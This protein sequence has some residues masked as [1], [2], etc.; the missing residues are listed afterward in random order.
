[1]GKDSK[2][3]KGKNRINPT[4]DNLVFSI[5]LLLLF[6]VVD[7]IVVVNYANISVNNSELDIFDKLI[8]L[9]NVIGTKD[10]ME[11]GSMLGNKAI[12]K[13]FFET[14]K[15]L[16]LV[17][18]IIIMI[19]ITKIIEPKQD[20]KGIEH[21]SAE[22]AK[23]EDRKRFTSSEHSFPLADSLFLSP[24]DKKADNFN[25]VVV[26]GP[27]AGKTLR[28]IKP[29]IMQMVGSYVITDPKGE[30]YR[31][32]CKLLEKNGY[33]VKVL[34]L[35]EPKF[36][37]GYN[38]FKYINMDSVE[39]DVFTLVNCF[40]RNTTDTKKQGGDQFW[41]D[42]VKALLT[43]IIFYL[44][45]DTDEDKCFERVFELTK[46][47][48]ID[49]ETG[50][51]N[52]RKSEIERI[53][54]RIAEDDPYHPGLQAW[55]EFKLASGKTA[56][57]ILIS[58]A[59]RLNIWINQDICS[60]TYQDEMEFE[61]VGVE[62]TAIF[63]ITPD[64]DDNFNVLASMFYTQLFKT[65]F[66]EA[67]FHYNGRLPLL[68]SCE[69]DEF[70][71]IGEIPNFDKYI[72]T[73]R[74][75]NVR[76][77]II[78]QALSQLEKLYK[79][80]WEIILGCCY[81]INYLGTTDTKTHK[82][83]SE[84]LGKTTTLVKNRGESKSS[85]SH[86]VNDNGNYIARD[87]MSSDEVS[88]L[89]GMNSIVF[90][91]GLNPFFCNKFDTLHHPLIKYVGSSFSDGIPNNTDI[92]KKYKDKSLMRMEEVRERREKKSQLISKFKNLEDDYADDYTD[93]YT[94]KQLEEFFE[95]NKL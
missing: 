30:V 80:S 39:T 16:V 92:H 89:D 60:M 93:D 72:A 65:L 48:I 46:N 77:C 45:L 61:K 50:E 36:S 69:L 81:I 47:V 79:E 87:L 26:G 57:S 3:F 82:F 73:M 5:F 7:V 66:Y 40:M 14:Q 29:E 78:L 17:Y 62:K 22:W 32:T 43:A 31:D 41:D 59:V 85:K 95:K 23:K 49:E 25:E 28:K 33:K 27:G 51:I 20:F 1:M 37:D 15:N 53:F 84:R 2:N 12:L 18:G 9:G 6:V 83:V 35:I 91:R 67:D 58:L 63:L 86:S 75:R 13:E 76:V 70:A 94:E 38:P 24:T 42:S 56:K 88:K 21:G 44:V 11:L 34:N 10:S 71:N 64:T 55:Q 52:P 8:R 4:K 68:V 90:I 19:A 54:T 74:S